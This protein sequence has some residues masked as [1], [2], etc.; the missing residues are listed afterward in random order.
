MLTLE[1][2]KNMDPGVFTH[3]FTEENFYGE[4]QKVL[5]VATRGAIHDWAIYV[6][7]EDWSIERVRDYGIKVHNMDLVS[8]LLP[9]ETEALQ[10]YRH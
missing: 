10:M 9:S 2:L 6:G 5:W 1:Q 8:Q 7:P 3:G 4:R